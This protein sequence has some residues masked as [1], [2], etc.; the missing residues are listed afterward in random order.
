MILYI[1]IFNLYIF[2]IFCCE[3]ECSC[4]RWLSSPIKI[5][6]EINHFSKLI[7]DEIFFMLLKTPKRL[8]ICFICLMYEFQ[9]FLSAS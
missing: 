2:A 9:Y 3:K 6:L 8:A 5:L 4:S 1:F 7:V